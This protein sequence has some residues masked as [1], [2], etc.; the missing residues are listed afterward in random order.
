MK[1]D[2]SLDQFFTSPDI[3]LQC[4]TA[5]KKYVHPKL[6]IEPSAGAGALIDAAKVVFPKASI[7]A[8][9]I[10]PKRSDIEKADFL[11]STID[12]Q[13]ETTLVFAN[14]PF[15][16]RSSLAIKFFNRS[17]NLA[18]TLAF[19]APVQFRKWSVQSKLDKRLKLVSDTLLPENSFV[20][21]GKPYNVRCCFQIWKHG[22]DELDLR[23]TKSLPI[24]HPDFI[25][26]QYNNTK[27]AL[28]IFKNKFDFAVPRQG[29]ADYTRRETK[30]SLC[31]LTTQWIL[32]RANNTKA[33]TNLKKLDFQ[34]L[35]ML[36]TSVP[37]FGKADVVQFYRE[38]YGE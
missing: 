16:K 8:Y 27:Q 25:M 7:I 1:H 2:K 22:G 32:F 21:D 10:D 34:K 20:F 18:N 29:Y 15:G 26:W 31:E 3:A 13:P 19:I 14:P 38:V 12:S 11:A 36:N 4:A 9:D 23:L 37:G 24:T 30:S 28:S 6:I 17:A 33:L 5:V 35:A